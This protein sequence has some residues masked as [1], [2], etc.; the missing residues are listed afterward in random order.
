MACLGS[1]V[2]RGDYIYDEASVQYTVPHLV[3]FLK[4]VIENHGEANIHIFGHGMG[5]SALVN[6]VKELSYIYTG[7]QV[8]KN[9]ILAT[10]D[11]DRDVFEV[12][13]YPYIIK[14]TDKITLYTSSDDKAL[15][16]SNAFHFGG[17]LGEGGDDVFVVEGLDTIDATVIDTSLLGHSYFNDQ[18][19]KKVFTGGHTGLIQD[20]I[21]KSIRVW[22]KETGKEK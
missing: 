5:A 22:D 15:K 20:I 10:P 13:L 8:F 9:I 18:K 3:D 17:R 19:K 4:K 14:T 16:V 6:A 1:G 12:S 2:F 7:K 11:I 21:N